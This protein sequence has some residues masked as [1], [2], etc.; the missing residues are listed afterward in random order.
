M[1]ADSLQQFIDALASCGRILITTHA[2]PDGDALGTTAAMALGLER[3]GIEAECLLLSPQPNK[4]E[5]VYGDA[6][7]K[8]HFIGEVPDVGS[9]LGRFDALLVCDTGTWSQLPGLRQPVSA[10]AGR[11]LVM[12]HHVTQEDW[13]DLKFVDTQAGAA[14]EMAMELLKRWGVPLDHALAQPLYVAMATDTGWFAFSNTSSRT[15]RM[16]AECVEAG[17]EPNLLY[18]RLYQGERS[19]RMRLHAAGYNSLELLADEQ[20]AVMQVTKGDFERTGTKTAAT[21]DLVN[22]PMA[23]GAVELVV[24][25]AENPDSA[26]G[27]PTKVSFR[28]KGRVDV[29]KLAEQF[30]GGGHPRAAGARVDASLAEARRRVVESALERFSRR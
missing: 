23:I 22:W 5:F 12:D 20:L 16:A 29:A 13:A 19:R 14:A 9:L 17:V 25:L 26:D 6:N 10:F 7:I 1:P 8:W 28:S 11:K 3:K 18:Q 27:R 24:F 2:N 4:Y 30:G 21:E 15:M